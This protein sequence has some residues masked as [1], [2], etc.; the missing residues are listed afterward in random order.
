[1]HTAARQALVQGGPSLAAR[2]IG[3]GQDQEATPV[4]PCCRLQLL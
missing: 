1:M 4:A 3:V 2:H